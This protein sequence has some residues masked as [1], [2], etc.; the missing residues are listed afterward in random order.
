MK[1]HKEICQSNEFIE[2]PKEGAFL[3]LENHIRS[4]KMPFVIYA[5][6][7]SLV[8][9]ISGCQTNPNE[10]FT[11]QFQKL[12]LAGFVITSNALLIKNTQKLRHIE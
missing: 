9:P 2:M 11:N 4:Q 3:K 12:N 6:F 8:E 5:D 10:C 7:E 1:I